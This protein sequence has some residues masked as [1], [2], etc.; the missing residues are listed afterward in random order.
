MA[1]ANAGDFFAHIL[2][3]GHALGLL[4]LAILFGIVLWGEARAK[5]PSE[6]WY[7]L[8]I[9]VLRTGAT[10]LADLMT[11]D[12]ALGSPLTVAALTVFLIAGRHRLW[13][14]KS[15]SDAEHPRAIAGDG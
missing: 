11:H 13:P 3:L 12:W 7:W 5:L 10:N 2:G 9:I 14:S 15:Q 4:P 8:A 1:G 6:V